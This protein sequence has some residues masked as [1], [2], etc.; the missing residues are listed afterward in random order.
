MANQNAKIDDSEV[1]T[2]LA[3]TDDSNQYIQR[4]LVDPVTG[5]LLVSV[6]NGG[7]VSVNVGTTTTGNAG[8]NA[9]VVNS[10][11]TIN[12]VFDFTIP[13][14]N[15]GATGAQGIQGIQGV[16]GDKGDKG[17]TG[18][19]AT[20]TAGSTATLAAGAP[21][22]VV[23]SGSTSAAVFDFGIPQG[24][25][26]ATGATG[27]IGMNW[28][29]AYDNAHTYAV[30]DGVSYLGSSY[31]NILIS[32]GNLPTNGTYWNLLAQKGDAT[33]VAP[34]VVT[35]AD[36]TS[37][38]VNAD[39]TDEATQSNT[40]AIGTL[41]MNA[42]T[43]TPVNGQK[44]L[45]RISSV[46]AQTFSWNAIFIPS[47]IASLPI[48]TGTGDIDFFGFIYNSVSSKWECISNNNNL[49]SAI[50]IS[51]ANG[52]SG[53]SSGGSTPALT[54]ALGAITPTSIGS[55]TTATKQAAW[56]NSTKLATTSY[57]DT[58][59]L[60]F[61]MKPDVAYAST[62][63]L[64]ANTYANGTLGVG[65]TLTGNANGPLVID[66]VTILVGQIGERVLVAGEAAPANNGWY[67]IT[68][69][70]VV[71]VSP[72]ILTRATE[73]DQA[74][75]I[76]A[77]Y[78][79]AVVAPNTVTPGTANNGK[80]FISIA[81]DPFTVGT[82]SLTF[83]QVGGTYTN[84]TGIGLSG[85]TFSIDTSVT[86]DKTTA[87]TLS[88]KT[89]TKPVINGTDP[90]GATYAPASGGQTVALDCATNNMHIVTGN[91]S[92]TAITFTVANA[93][94]NQPFIVSILQGSG[95]VSTIVGWFATVRWAGGVAPTLTATLN[96]RDTFGFI[97]T[98]SNTYDGFII[99][100]NC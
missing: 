16:K 32:T 30:N 93:T 45:L 8:T 21:A 13:R 54:I 56:D 49:V 35:I 36:A 46:N 22:T 24:I 38:T 25:Q 89:L 15:T 71:A 68:Q 87:Q 75:E 80:V 58:A 9:N 40:Q 90:T 4:V 61:A 85:N 33:F 27:A 69:Q 19:A 86:V 48:A 47:S 31:I 65:A 28:T 78:Q 44:L 10:G 14:G 60:T 50:T 55:A 67:T 20:A 64:P 70:G 84:G 53:S 17:D 39:T 23:N 12:A 26:G 76:G 77:G 3:V 100:Q 82:T 11:T 79:T 52:V 57:V 73:S 97:R 83:A 95:T 43:G 6:G 1:P 59:L 34:R 7:T 92:G 2:L 91:A 37:I 88:S 66:S 98:G 51:T 99:G 63:A 18:T 62:S 29:G 72:Y 5:R 96:K 94:N 42:P 74:A 81:A 41:T